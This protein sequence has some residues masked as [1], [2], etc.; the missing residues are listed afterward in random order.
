MDYR[1]LTLLL[2]EVLAGTHDSKFDDVLKSIHCMSRPRVYAVLNACVSAMD[3]GELYVEVGT[4]QGGSLISALLGNT[5]R[6]IGVD[7]FSEFQQTNSKDR[8]RENL[9]KFGV[10]ERVA[11]LDLHYRD[12]FGSLP[13]NSKIH[14]YNYDGEHGYEPQLAG[15]EA[16]WRFL[17]PG[18][19]ILVDDLIYPEV[20]RA[21]NQ[22]ISNHIESVKIK[23]VMLPNQNT[24][25]V[26]WNGVCVLQVI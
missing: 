20:I 26:W 17:V 22:F 2:N 11:L 8:T 5:A 13:A 4:Y 15:M 12:F 24:D 18:A 19:L 10:S 1:K 25:D 9:E 3:P 6:A 16:A 7:N 14:V 23:F 21:V